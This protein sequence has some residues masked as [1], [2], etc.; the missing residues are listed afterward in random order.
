MSTGR[1]NKPCNK[2]SD[3]PSPWS[4]KFSCKLCCIAV[5]TTDGDSVDDESTKGMPNHKTSINKYLF[6]KTTIPSCSEFCTPSPLA[7]Q[8]MHYAKLFRRFIFTTRSTKSMKQCESVGCQ[9]DSE[10]FRAKVEKSPSFLEFLSFSC[11][12]IAV[13]SFFLQQN[14]VQRFQM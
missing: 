7:T 11:C 6:L 9:T 1:E 5:L 8:K 3:K 2:E 4:P 10:C 14:E 12:K 13:H